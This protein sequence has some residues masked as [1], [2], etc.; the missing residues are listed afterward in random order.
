MKR[1]RS[2]DGQLSLF[3]ILDE[4]EK[5]QSMKI[6][7]DK[8]EMMVKRCKPQ[9]A[10]SDGDD[11]CFTTVHNT[12][13]EDTEKAETAL[14]DKQN[15]EQKPTLQKTSVMVPGYAC[16]DTIGEIFSHIYGNF[17]EMA[18]SVRK[19]KTRFKMQRVYGLKEILYMVRP[20]TLKD[21]RAVSFSSLGITVADET[22]NCRFEWLEIEQF[23]SENK[24]YDS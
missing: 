14:K 22:R 18:D 13:S 9:I 12:Q 11:E 5:A 6:E 3:D 20:F 17:P 23:L 16:D 1:K 4:K 2:D 24:L 15:R 19:L 21:G 10:R 7:A 8:I